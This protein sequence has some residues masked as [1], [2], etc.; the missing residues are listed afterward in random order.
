MDPASST[1]PQLKSLLN[2]TSKAVRVECQFKFLKSSIE[3]KQNPD[4]IKSQCTFKSSI[5]D[6]ELQ[7]L[8]D[9][10][11]NFTASRIVDILVAY[12]CNWK[13]DLWKAHY[14]NLAKLEKSLTSDD[15]NKA[16]VIFHKHIR[17]EKSKQEKALKS[18]LSRDANKHPGP[19]YIPNISNKTTT[20]NPTNHKRLRRLTKKHQSQK[21]KRKRSTR[22]SVPSKRRNYLR[23]DKILSREDIPE[24]ELKKSIINLSS[25]SLTKEH[26]FVFHLFVFHLGG[27]FAP[28]PKLPNQMR[29]KDDVSTWIRK[30]RTA[31]NISVMQKD[32]QSLKPTLDVS[33][34][35]LDVAKMERALIPAPKKNPAISCTETKGH[36]LE[37]FISKINEKIRKF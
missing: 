8:L 19:I 9:N 37:L 24:E 16:L 29:F 17:N 20:T 18:K 35:S 28:T 25:K 34:L 23:D 1:L 30:M 33:S 32:I 36:A 5:H 13:N 11:M 21:P 15:F 14:S 6:P 31:F 27:S 12:Y 4:G 22:V 3:A 10:M 26:L 2:V 7:L